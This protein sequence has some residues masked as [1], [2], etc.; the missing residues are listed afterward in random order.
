M[1]FRPNFEY[2]KNKKIIFIKVILKLECLF[3][4]NRYILF[5]LILFSYSH[6]DSNKSKK[7]FN[8]KK[9]PYIF[10]FPSFN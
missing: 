4:Y 7:S 1:V 10:T 2:L 3:H 9:I 6:F 8:R 5:H